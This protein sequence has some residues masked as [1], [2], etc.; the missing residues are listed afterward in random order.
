MLNVYAYL[1]LDSMVMYGRGHLAGNKR[2]KKE[3]GKRKGR[4][5]KYIR[6]KKKRKYMQWAARHWSRL[7][8]PPLFNSNEFTGY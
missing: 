2:V 3:G 1:A 5:Q 4:I 8:V 6:R 7:S